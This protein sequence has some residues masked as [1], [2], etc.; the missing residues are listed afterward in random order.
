MANDFTRHKE[1]QS[2]SK[3]GTIQVLCRVGPLVES[4]CFFSFL[5]WSF[6]GLVLSCVP[7]SSSPTPTKS[8]LDLVLSCVPLSPFPHPQILPWS[9]TV[10]RFPLH[11]PKSYLGLVLSCVPLPPLPLPRSPFPRLTLVSYCLASL[12]AVSR[13]ADSFSDT[14]FSSANI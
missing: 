11:S 4:C 12:S 1:N 10:L 9:R 14:A 13:S 2:F 8:Y 6:F 5:A 7:F 3:K